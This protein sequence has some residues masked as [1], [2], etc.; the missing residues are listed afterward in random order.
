MNSTSRLRCRLCICILLTR[1][2]S[3]THAHRWHGRLTWM[4]CKKTWRGSNNLSWLR[5]KTPLILSYSRG[6]WHPNSSLRCGFQLA[7]ATQKVLAARPP[8]LIRPP[9][10]QRKATKHKRSGASST[11]TTS[12]AGHPRNTCEKHAPLKVEQWSGGRKVCSVV[13]SKDIQ[14][15]FHVDACTDA[16]LPELQRRQKLHGLRRIRGAWRAFPLAKSNI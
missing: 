1:T 2:L 14:E 12:N 11:R 5:C 10:T 7:T 4:R 15:E 3:L 6:S 13:H 9:R 16:Q 8:T